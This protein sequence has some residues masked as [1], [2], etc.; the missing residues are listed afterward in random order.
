MRSASLLHCTFDTIGS[1]QHIL[2]GSGV[3]HE[4]T[5]LGE[6]NMRA[7]QENWEKSDSRSFRWSVLAILQNNVGRLASRVVIKRSCPR[8]T[9]PR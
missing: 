3:V 2:L 8:L 5:T 1:E 7:F 4:Y 6:I 9:G